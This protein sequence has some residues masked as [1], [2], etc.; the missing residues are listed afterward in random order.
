MEGG[1]WYS[2]QAPFL[3]AYLT[4]PVHFRF[5]LDTL[6]IEPA[7]V[8]SPDALSPTAPTLEDECTTAM[9]ILR[10][11]AQRLDIDNILDEQQDVREEMIGETERLLADARYEVTGYRS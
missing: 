4:A 5:A 11:S 8:A 9:A 10:R 6:R 2:L 3:F 7:I 1:G